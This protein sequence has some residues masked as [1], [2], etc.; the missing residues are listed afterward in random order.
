MLAGVPISVML[1]PNSEENDSG[2]SNR[3][4]GTLVRRETPMTTGNNIAVAPTLLMNADMTPQVIMMTTMRRTSLVPATRSMARP[5]TSATPVS[6][7]PADT[8]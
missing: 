7:I 4:I 6:S 3:K 8:M 2:I 5:I 1:P